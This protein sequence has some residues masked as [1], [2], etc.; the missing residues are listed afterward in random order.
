M[1]GIYGFTKRGWL[2]PINF[3]NAHFY[4]GVFILF[5]CRR[6]LL[7][8]EEELERE[9]KRK[10]EEEETEWKK[11]GTATLKTFCAVHG[12]SDCC[13]HGDDAASTSTW[14]SLG[15]VEVTRVPVCFCPGPLRRTP[16]NSKYEQSPWRIGWLDID[17][18]DP[19]RGKSNYPPPP[20]P[21]RRDWAVDPTPQS[22]DR[23]C[24]FAIWRRGWSQI[25][26][27]CSPGVPVDD[28]PSTRRPRTV[29]GQRELPESESI[30][31][32]STLVS[33]RPSS[34]GRSKTKSSLK[35]GLGEHFFTW[36]FF[37]QTRFFPWYM[38]TLT[39]G[40][41]FEGQETRREYMGSLPISS[42]DEQTIPVKQGWAII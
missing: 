24:H 32:S 29:L 23:P 21:P 17:S 37:L 27:Q 22:S 10:R 12:Y 15:L 26:L 33:L 40:S 34:E 5:S 6:R 31:R 9:R 7:F 16:A 18:K 38:L 36:V 2:L 13:C 41:G 30:S 25:S 35:T 11:R 1:K 28:V 14:Q 4:R 39:Y 20:P 19:P 3:Q 8:I 42:K